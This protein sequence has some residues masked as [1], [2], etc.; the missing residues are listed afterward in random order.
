MDWEKFLIEKNRSNALSLKRKEKILKW[1][2]KYK[3]VMLNKKILGKIESLGNEVC[4]FYDGKIKEIRN[5][6]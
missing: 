2:E 4:F 6:K 5:L 3:K 1:Q